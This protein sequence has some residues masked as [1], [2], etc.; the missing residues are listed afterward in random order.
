ME[1]AGTAQSTTALTVI[2]NVMEY[3]ANPEDSDESDQWLI[4]VCVRAVRE[5]L[6]NENH[7]AQ[8]HRSLHLHTKSIGWPAKLHMLEYAQ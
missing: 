8:G 2:C 7:C 6:Q 3:L 4:L 5:P 1:K